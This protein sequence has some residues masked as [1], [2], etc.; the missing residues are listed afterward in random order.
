MVYSACVISPLPPALI[1]F[2][3]PSSVLPFV[4]VDVYSIPFKTTSSTFSSSLLRG[5]GVMPS[6]LSSCATKIGEG[7]WLPSYAVPSV[8]ARRVRLTDR[9]VCSASFN[10]VVKGW[11]PLDTLS[12]RSSSRCTSLPTT[13]TEPPGSTC[14]APAREKV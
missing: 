11:P 14:G 10:P 1:C 3:P 5:H 6:A 2:M 12:R 9:G 7:S 13:T 8:T 4:G